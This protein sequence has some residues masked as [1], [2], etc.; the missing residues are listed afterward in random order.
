[1]ENFDGKELKGEV[2]EKEGNILIV[3]LE[4]NGISCEK[5]GL[6]AS[7]KRNKKCQIKI[8]SD[9]SNIN[10]GD[11]VR[12]FYS[13]KR[14]IQMAFLIFIVPVIIFLAV[15]AGSVEANMQNGVPVIVAFILIVLYFAV[16]KIFF[17]IRGVRGINVLKE[18]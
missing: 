17:K 14:G 10:V 8:P 18:T 12:I 15:V 6:C 16:L 13:E 3:L 9:N 2:I 7:K 1:M 4:D 11:K 5:C